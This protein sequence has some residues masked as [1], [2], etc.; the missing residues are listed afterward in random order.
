MVVI[1]E[2]KEKRGLR[3]PPACP[4]RPAPGPALVQARVSLQDEAELVAVPCARAL[5]PQKPILRLGHTCAGANWYRGG[6]AH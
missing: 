4:A 5:S 2:K 3:R 6:A 1:A